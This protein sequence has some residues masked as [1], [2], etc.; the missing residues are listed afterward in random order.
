MGYAN[1][2]S[3]GSEKEDLNPHD[4]SPFSEVWGDIAWDGT[5]YCIYKD[6]D[7]WSRVWIAWFSGKFKLPTKLEEE[8]KVQQQQQ[9]RTR[10][11][12]WC[13]AILYVGD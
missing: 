8:I 13:S 12:K 9:P 10:V 11:I 6:F 2:N 4:T 3:R 5:A 1:V 7:M